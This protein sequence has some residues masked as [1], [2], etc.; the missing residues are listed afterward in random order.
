M[1]LVEG[2]HDTGLFNRSAAINTAARLAG[3]WD[4]AVI[5]DSDVICDIEPVFEAI[6]IAKRTNQM[7]LPYEVR[8]DLNRDGTDRIMRG[9]EGNW[10]RFV[11]VRYTDGVSSV[12]V[13]NRT[14][15]D[16]VGGFD[17]AFQGWGWED[18]AFRAACVTFGDGDF[19]RLEGTVWHL[20]H[21]TAKTEARG[22]PSWSANHARSERY[23]TNA[24]DPEA[25]RA[26]QAEAIAQ[27]H[28]LTIPKIL[29][30]VVPEEITLTAEEYWL[31][32]MDLHPGWRVLTHQD[33]LRPEDW[34]KTSPVWKYV[35][36]GAQ[37][38]DLIRL[39]A[40]E[41]WGGVY[42]DQDVEPYRSLDPLLGVEMFAAWEDPVSVP[43]AVVGARP[44]HPAVSRCLD[45]AIRRVRQ[46][47]G[48][49]QAGPGV[50][51]D[52][53]PGRDDVL[54]LPPGTFYPYHYNQK[55]RATAD[56]RKEQPWA[57]AAHHW[58]GSWLEKG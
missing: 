22:T 58:W 10:D 50:F 21:R 37:L 45:T 33:P 18:N 30:R 13:L 26:I 25:I 55:E 14:L 31:K 11:R 1:P 39:E 36:A 51:T 48:I 3:A 2:H 28:G 17:E 19:I 43:N 57:F 49:W 47:K 52:I 38:A 6:E 16:A 24:G 54:L 29:H 42:V 44:H 53:L 46:R 41:R 9:Y 20:Y 12:V 23:R 8:K 7:V 56:H 5:I 40:L 4:V 35:E 34:P 15:W 32:W 27:H